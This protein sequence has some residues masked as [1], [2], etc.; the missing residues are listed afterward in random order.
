MAQSHKFLSLWGAVALSMIFNVALAQTSEGEWNLNGSAYGLAGNYN[1]SIERDD[2]R[3]FGAYLRGD[4]LERAGYTIGYVHTQVNF[5]SGQ[6]DISQDELYLSGRY[7]LTPDWT[8][9][10]VSLRLD[11]HFISNDDSTGA[12]D[13]VT[14]VAPM[15]SFLNLEK[16]LYLDLGYA[17]SSYGSS[18][19]IPDD[20]D[21]DQWTPTIGLGFNQN[22][23]WIQARGYYI[24]PS[25]SARALGKDDTTA[26]E[27]K[28]THWFMPDAPLGID[29]FKLG[30]L[31]GKRIFAVDPDTG[32][33]YN[34]ADIQTG[35]LS[36]S[37]GWKLPEQIRLLVGGGYE[38][39]ENPAINDDY[40]S[41]Y[42]YISVSKD[43]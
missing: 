25:S 16:T 3:A 40:D 20:L 26:L 32:A 23:D 7:H 33:V 43:W 18:S 42:L 35:G 4:Y 27:V 9:G 41:Y 21:I 11:G 8:T 31:F 39:Y 17:R 10:K 15:V 34:L 22:A 29:D 36:L 24:D 1:G 12:T 5:K 28:W 2:V 30:A 19:T 14:V 38:E 13:D 6:N 37:G